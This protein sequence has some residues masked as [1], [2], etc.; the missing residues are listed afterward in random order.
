MVPTM[1]ALLL[2]QAL[3][4]DAKQK[5]ESV[6]M[7]T[8]PSLAH[9]KWLNDEVVN[10][11]IKL[12]RARSLRC[13]FKHHFFTSF[14]F[15]K[16]LDE[17]CTK[18]FMYEN[19]QSW[20]RDVDLF[21]LDKVFVPIN[22]SKCHWTFLVAYMEERKMKYFDSLGGD[23]MFYLRHFVAYL[24]EEWNKRNC[25]S[26]SSSLR[27][28][29]WTFIPRPTRIP[30]QP[31][32][33][34]CGVFVCLYADVLSLDGCTMPR[35][36]PTTTLADTRLLI[37]FLLSAH[38]SKSDFLQ[39][40]QKPSV[41]G[42]TKRAI[43]ETVLISDDVTTNVPRVSGK[44]MHAS[45]NPTIEFDFCDGRRSSPERYTKK[46]RMVVLTDSK[47]TNE[48]ESTGVISCTKLS[49]A[50]PTTGVPIDNG[51]RLRDSVLQTNKVDFCN[52]RQSF[53]ADK[54]ELLEAEA[55]SCRKKPL[56]LESS[57]GVTSASRSKKTRSISEITDSLVAFFFVH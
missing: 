45:I 35:N 5:A 32:S 1:P 47:N 15:T 20:T 50:E 42:S 23:G 55:K 28:D 16:L 30:Q 31:N 43:C 26:D 29:E 54:K 51:K 56:V 39:K 24:S 18:T 49:S 25:R 33:F 10:G 52:G 7:N 40:S 17:E 14:F 2:N 22:I 34:D 19:V 12:L 13:G 57:L 11:V 9:G 21:T 4:P 8:Y 46:V 53:R 48:C 27:E 38:S 41:E 36:F 37:A 6:I 44:R 3:G